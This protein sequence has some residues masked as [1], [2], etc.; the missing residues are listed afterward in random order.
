VCAFALI[1]KFVLGPTANRYHMAAILLVLDDLSTKHENGCQTAHEH[2]AQSVVVLH[3]ELSAIPRKCPTEKRR[4]FSFLCLTDM[5]HI[6][7]F[8]GKQ[9]KKQHT[10]QFTTKRMAIIWCHLTAYFTSDT[11]LRIF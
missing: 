3:L 8:N 10:N 1:G 4:K 5:F 6:N 9:K 7:N 2:K 11:D